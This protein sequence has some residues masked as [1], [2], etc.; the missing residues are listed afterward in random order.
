MLVWM[1]LWGNV[2]AA[3][4]IGGL[5]VALVITLLL[6]LPAVPIEGR[7]HPLSLLRLV[8]VGRLLPGAVLGAGGVAG[9]QAGAAAAD[10]GAAG[11]RWRSSRIW[12][13]RWPST[14]ST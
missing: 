12:C 11:A 3:N 7:L 13:W 4:I 1:L 2:S 5:A 14:S 9:D 8:V 6:P 10:R